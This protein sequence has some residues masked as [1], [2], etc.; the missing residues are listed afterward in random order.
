V[1]ESEWIDC[2]DPLTLLAALPHRVHDRALRLAACALWR[3][4]WRLTRSNPEREA[5]RIAERFADG[6]ATLSAL[7]SRRS[8]GM[9]LAE[10]RGNTALLESIRA[11]CDR[12]VVGGF[13]KLN[14]EEECLKDRISARDA[15]AL[16]ELKESTVALIR[17]V[18]GNPFRRAEMR[19]EWRVV[20]DRAVLIVAH[21]IYQERAFDRMPILA[22][23]LQDAGCDDH[24]LI[25]HCCGAG[26]HV[27]G[28]WVLDLVLGKG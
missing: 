10:S 6:D 13:W 27:P 3:R 16:A 28:C 11:V 18:I 24:L 19:Q 14:C 15:A 5:V 1:T 2:S 12:L 22:N 7:A 9:G 25:D 8:A 17:E 4:Y 21:G 20:N 26:E 23:A